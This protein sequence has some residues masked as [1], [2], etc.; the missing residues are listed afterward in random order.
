[1]RTR[2]TGLSQPRP[3]VDLRGRDPPGPV[4][5]RLAPIMTH[6]SPPPRPLRS[7]PLLVLPLAL[8]ASLLAGCGDSPSE[9]EPDPVV[10]GSWSGASQGLT[11]NLTPNE[12]VGGAVSGS[13][14]TASEV[15]NHALTV[16][17]GT[18]TYP[19]LSLVL[20][21]SGFQSLNLT[22]RMV[23]E[24]GISGTLNGSGFDDFNLNL[25]RR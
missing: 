3:I 2:Q 14:N 12:G 24:D 10:S 4:P 20:G 16:Q 7:A 22:G 5:P 21:A 13:G 9:P 6:T 25:R 17:Q 1:M 19:N 11:L 8:T 23:S 18:H 15:D